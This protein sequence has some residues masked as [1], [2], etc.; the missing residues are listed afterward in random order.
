[1]V[2]FLYSA[3]VLFVSYILATVNIRAI[4]HKQYLAAALTD[5]AIPL[6]TFFLVRQ[7][8][9]TTSWQTAAGMATGGA[10]S[11]MLGIWLTRVWDE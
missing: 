11:S 3:I 5:T 8:G 7:I 2:D 1:M 4:A 9:D 10:L 6:T